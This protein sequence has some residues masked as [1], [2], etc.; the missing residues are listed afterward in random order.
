MAT[1]DVE[2]IRDRLQYVLKSDVI[3]SA[4]NRQ[5]LMEAL[6][7]TYRD[8][9]KSDRAEATRRGLGSMAD[10]EILDILWYIHDNPRIE[11]RVYGE[12]FDLDGGRISEILGSNTTDRLNRIRA[13]FDDGQGGRNA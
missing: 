5:Y 10:Q 7:K 9:Y 11:N 1:G 3:L 4:K 12:I 8:S 6:E 2:Y 13:V